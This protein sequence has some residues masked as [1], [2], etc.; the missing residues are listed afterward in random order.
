LTEALIAEVFKVRAQ[1]APSTLHRGLQ[2]Q[3]LP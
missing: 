1:V 2:I 3:Y